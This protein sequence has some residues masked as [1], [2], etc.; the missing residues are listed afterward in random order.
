MALPECDRINSGTSTWWL[1]RASN[2]T[3]APR[4]IKNEVFK[5]LNKAEGDV[6][7]AV[8]ENMMGKQAP[9]FLSF[10]PRLTGNGQQAA[11]ATGS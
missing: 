5:I 3:F 11:P 9:I 8:I 2:V 10:G 7:D 1:F 4:A 6:D